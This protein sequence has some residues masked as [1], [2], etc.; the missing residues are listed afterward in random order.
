MN[1]YADS[2]QSISAHGLSGL[3]LATQGAAQVLGLEENIG[4][5]AAGKL[6]DVV[7][8]DLRVLD[9]RIH[10]DGVHVDIPRLLTLGRANQAVTDVWIAGSRR[11]NG[12]QFID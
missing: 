10:A 7:A 3:V 9:A 11:I 5:L 12:R 1:Y 2:F 4:T 8:L 6:A